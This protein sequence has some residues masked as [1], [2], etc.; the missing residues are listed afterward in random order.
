MEKL[1]IQDSTSISEALYD[2]ET[3]ILE[4]EFLNQARYEYLE[5]T[6]ETWL[7]FKSASSKGNYFHHFLRKGY[8]YNR[9][10]M[11]DYSS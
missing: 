3:K 10:Q 8:E 2:E 1:I 7:E 5:V 11:P 9:I 4:I 6:K